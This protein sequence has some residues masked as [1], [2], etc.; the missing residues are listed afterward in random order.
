M[1]H[2]SSDKKKKSD[3]RNVSAFGDFDEAPEKSV[4]KDAPATKEKK[5]NKVEPVEISLDGGSESAPPAR[6]KKAHSKTTWFIVGA[7]FAVILIIGA[8]VFFTTNMDQKLNSPL[9]INGSNVD[10]AE[11]S[12]MY[13]YVLIEN[14]VDIFAS[15]TPDMLASECEDTSFANNRDFFLDQTAQELQTIQILYDDAT[16]KGYSIEQVHYSRANAYIDW[17]QGKASELGVSLDT[18]IRG[19]FGSQ[20]DEQCVINTLARKYFTEDYASNEK[21]VEL[22]A[23]SEQAEAAYEEDSNTYDL[24]NYKMLRITYEQR[25][26][27]FIETAQVHANEIVEAMGHD[28]SKFESCASDYFSG[29]AQQNLLQPDSTLISN[30]RYSDFTHTEFRDWLFDQSRTSG[31]TVIFNDTDGFPIILCFVS[32]DR[33]TEALRDVDLI[34]IKTDVDGV[35]GLAAGDGQAIAQSIYDS[36]TDAASVDET[37]NLYNDYVL[38]GNVALIESTD[39]Y[40]GQYDD[41][42]NDWIFSDERQDG[43][44]GLIITTDGFYVI[45]FNSVSPNPEWYDRVNSFIRMNN[46]QAFMNEMRTE[47]EYEFISSGLDDIQDVP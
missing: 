28:E 2:R 21:L 1:K 25:T 23:T 26:D 5:K 45:Y 32:R 22:Q 16:S 42:I 30:A 14:G 31:D 10:S 13:H 41:A 38:E 17:L 33:K 47:Y 43:D 9:S 19:V 18:Y 15:D 40:D 29:E 11:F 36:I 37:I 39:T 12:F 8:T 3:V 34:Q 6:S 27:A 20:V 44:K 7:V 4:K 46:Y 35:T 24:V